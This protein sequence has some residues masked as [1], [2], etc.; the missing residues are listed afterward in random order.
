MTRKEIQLKVLELFGLKIGDKVKSLLYSN[1]I[2]TIEEID[3]KIKLVNIETGYK[4]SIS[5]LLDIDWE[6][7]EPPVKD[8]KCIDF[9]HCNGCPFYKLRAINCCYITKEMDSSMV[10]R[11]EGL[12]E[13]IK[14]LK[15]KIYGEEE[16]KD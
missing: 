7:I 16:W 9:E 14:E 1:N 6:K 4:E 5:L 8:K 12:N 2:Y 10:E 3:K 13:I 11:Y 15:T